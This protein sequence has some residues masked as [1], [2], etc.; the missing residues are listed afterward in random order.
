MIIRRGLA[1]SEVGRLVLY[2]LPN[3]VVLTIPMALLFAILIAIGRLASDSELVA[4]RACGISLFTLYRP[5]LL[6]SAVLASANV[7]ISAYMLPRANHALQV[8]TLEILAQT[9]ARQVEPRVFY[10][11][12]EGLVLYVFSI[13]PGSDVWEGVFMAPSVQQAQNQIHVAKRGRLQVD[14]AGERIVLH[15][16]DALTHKVDLDRP[17]NYELIRH[18]TLDVLLDD[19][20]TSNQRA[21]LVATKGVR[22]LNLTELRQWQRDSKLD[23]ELHRLV[24][25]EIH[26]KIAIPA[27]CLVFGL[28]AVPLGF[29]NRRGGKSSG[30]AL[31]IAVIMAF[32]VLL[33][34]GEDA[35][36]VGRVPPWLAMWFPNLLFSALGAFLLVRRNQDRGLLGRRFG[37]WVR[38]VASGR[39]LEVRRRQ[40]KRRRIRRE[41]RRRAVRQRTPDVVLRIPRFALRFPNLLDRYVGKMFARVF[42]VVVMAGVVLYILADFTDNVDD[43]LKH[44]PGLGVLLEYYSYMSLQVFFDIAPILVLVTTLVT[45]ALLSRTNEITSAKALGVSLY[46]LALP[47]VACAALVAGLGVLLQ[48]EV[49]PAS[50]QRVAQLK[51]RM[52]GQVTARTYRRIDR[53]WLFGRGGYIFNYL[54]YDQARQQL[55]DLQVFGFDH[56][57]QL[58]QRLFSSQA[59]WEGDRWVLERGWA[60]TFTGP[61]ERGFQPFAEP[62]LSPYQEGPD[63]FASE[64]KS[65]E[66]MHYGELR[67][68]VEEV[69]QSGQAAPEL[70]VKLY[71]KFA[72]PALSLI[73]ALVALPFAFR[74]GRRGAL[75]GVGLSLVLGMVLLG[76]FAF[77]STLGGVGTLPPLVAVWAPSLIFA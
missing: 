21:K 19:Q 49:L 55:N 38:L 64:V 3:I 50:N 61:L 45:F 11:E 18:E 66:Q 26:K 27:A 51:D 20:F 48:V 63:Y 7:Y 12:W 74:L 67:R 15:L 68:Y 70:E 47:A 8:Q 58:A 56:E 71:D 13:Q 33:S 35:A 37:W 46:R 1:A 40:Q 17:E 41:A 59:R 53:Q 52:K 77:F 9:A 32:Y 24:S 76:V 25:V 4:M 69:R 16:E 14:K 60:R 29:N 36:R 44:K 57:H 54:Y 5:I 75:Y 6:L 31:S 43:V 22:E 42:L 65:P 30:F 2:T 62:V 73:M 39:L 28:F 34:N 72:R 23:P 10:E